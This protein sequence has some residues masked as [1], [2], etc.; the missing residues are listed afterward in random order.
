MVAMVNPLCVAREA[1]NAGSLTLLQN[2]TVAADMWRRTGQQPK[3][4]ASSRG[5]LLAASG[6]LKESLPHVARPM[7]HHFGAAVFR[8]V[9]TV[10][11]PLR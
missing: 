6:V 11:G 4:S 2:P 7:G 8:N 10:A 1:G 5:Q 3:P 9:S